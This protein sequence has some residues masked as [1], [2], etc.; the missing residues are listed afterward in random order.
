MFAG[1]EREVMQVETGTRVPVVISKDET[2][3]VFENLEVSGMMICDFGVWPKRCRQDARWPRQPRRLSYF[4]KIVL[5]TSI[6]TGDEPCAAAY[7]CDGPVEKRDGYPDLAR[8]ARSR[9]CEDDGDLCAR[10]R[11]GE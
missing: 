7:L 8:A 10:G 9:G 6:E 4:A 1:G 5:R 2:Q 3:R 11:S